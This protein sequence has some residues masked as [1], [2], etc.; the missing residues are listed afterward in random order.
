MVFLAANANLGFS[1]IFIE[2]QHNVESLQL[3]TN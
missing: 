1:F 2:I 3:S